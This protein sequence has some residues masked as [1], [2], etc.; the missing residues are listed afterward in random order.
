MIKDNGVGPN[1]VGVLRKTESKTWIKYFDRQIEGMFEFSL[2][3]DNF[4]L[5]LNKNSIVKLNKLKNII[6]S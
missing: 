4:L 6:I 2:Q 1:D 3:F 5:H